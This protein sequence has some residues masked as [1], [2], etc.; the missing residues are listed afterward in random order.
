VPGR[1]ARGARVVV[2]DEVVAVEPAGDRATQRDRLD[3]LVM[4]AVR[5]AA[6]T[7]AEP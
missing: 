7:S 4:L 1:A 6:R 5:S 2:D 3:R